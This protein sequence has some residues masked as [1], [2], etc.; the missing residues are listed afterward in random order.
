MHASGA[1]EGDEEVYYGSDATK[2]SAEALSGFASAFL[3]NELSPS[4]RRDTSAPAEDDDGVDESAVTTLTNDNFDQ[5]S[6]GP[7]HAACRGPSSHAHASLAA[8]ASC[9]A[10]RVSAARKE[11]AHHPWLRSLMQ[12]ASAYVCALSQ[13]VRDPTK[14]VLV[15]F[16]AP[17]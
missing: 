4:S 14:D 5:A 16:Y 17:W 3:A 1:Q 8:R 10:V 7:P 11:R 15:E 9:A 2:F 6:R 12:R 13:V